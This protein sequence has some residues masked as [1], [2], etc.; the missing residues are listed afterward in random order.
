MVGFQVKNIKL[1]FSYDV[2]MSGLKNY[3]GSRGAA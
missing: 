2:T 1:S 3:N